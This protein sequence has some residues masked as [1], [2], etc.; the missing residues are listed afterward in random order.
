[1]NQQFKNLTPQQKETYLSNKQEVQSIRKQ[2]IQKFPQMN[3]CAIY[4]NPRKKA[5]CR[6]KFYLIRGVKKDELKQFIEQQGWD[7][8]YKFQFKNDKYYGSLNL[9]IVVG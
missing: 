8:K 2:I 6:S 3:W 5:E 1:M 4:T 9:N 7:S